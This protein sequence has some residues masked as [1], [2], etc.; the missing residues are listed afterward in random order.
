[1]DK[2]LSSRIS[3]PGASAAVSDWYSTSHLFCLP[4]RWEGFPNALAEALAHGL[5]S[6]GFAGCAGVPDLI[7]PGENGLLAEGNGEVNALAKALENLMASADKRRAMGAR[8]A[9]SVKGYDPD[10]VFSLW[11]RVLA[12]ATLS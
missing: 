9:E 3:L 10:K 5:P 6:V 4:S 8:A 12:E 1:M 2:G 7:L 11:E